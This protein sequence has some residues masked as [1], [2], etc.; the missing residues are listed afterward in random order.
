MGIPAVKYRYPLETVNMQPPLVRFS[1]IRLDW[2]SFLKR[3]LVKKVRA[4]SLL[5]IGLV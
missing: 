2:S 3:P 5:Y 1:I 4:Y